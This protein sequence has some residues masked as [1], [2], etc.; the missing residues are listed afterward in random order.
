MI[1]DQTARGRAIQDHETLFAVDAGAGTGKTTLL[2]SRLI[3]LL[4]E[5][6]V[7]LGKIA[8]ITFTEKAA[9]ELVDR[10]RQKLEKELVENPAKK[11][12]ILQAFQ[13]LERA[14]ISTIHSFCAALLREYP[15][16]AGVDPRFTILDDVQAGAFESQAWEDWLKK[17][18]NKPV[19]SL[20]HFQRLGGTFGHLEE[21]KSF[22]KRN[23]SLL[24]PPESQALPDSADFRRAL[25]KFLQ[26]V[27]PLAS[28]CKD[29]SDGL[30]EAL[31][32]F[33]GD[34]AFLGTVSPEEM[35]FGLAVLEIPKTAK[36]GNQKNWDKTVLDNI[37]REFSLLSGEHEIFSAAFKNA[38]VLN[39]VHW[40]W[41]YLK[42]FEEKKNR[43]GFLDFDDLLMRTRNLLKDH[44]EAR[45]ELKK[46]LD[47]L[48]VDEFQDTDPLQVEIVFFLAEKEGKSETNWK[49]VKLKPG[50][51]FL[52]GDPKQSIY[53][54]RRADVE[55]YEETKK[56]VTGNGG[57]VELLTE[58][59][60]TVGS[61][62]DWVNARF[63]SLFTGTP[64]QYSA[65]NPS[66]REKRPPK[67]IPPLIGIRI[68]VP[69]DEKTAKA[70]LRHREAEWTAAFISEKLLK[71]GWTLS[72]PKT[73]E[74]R[75]VEPGD[76][77]VLFRDLSNENEEFWEEAFRKRNLSYQIVGGKRFYKRPEI[78]ALSTLLN[79]L[80]S[81]ADEA[82]CVA[83][84]RS[85]LFGF[86][87]EKIFLHRSSGGVF[88]FL[89]PAQKDM[90]E[91]FSL[92][93]DLYEKTRTLSVSETLTQFL[94]KTN[95]LAVVAAQ[96]HG[97]QRVA[98][99][100]KVVDQA[101]ELETSQHF[102]Y[103]AFTQWLAAQQE[104]ET[105]EGEAP[106]PDSSENRVT[107]MTI[108]KAKGLEF[109][110]VIVSGAASDSKDS[111]SLLE[112]KNSAGAYKAGNIDLG[113]RTLNY[114]GVRSEEQ[115][116]WEAENTRLL[117]VA[118]T[119]AMECL[120]LPFFQLPMD[121]RIKSEDLFLAPLLAGLETSPAQG[122][123]DLNPG[124][125][126]W[127]ENPEPGKVSQEDPPA[128]VVD[129]DEK[130]LKTPEAKVEKEKI[131]AQE[132]SRRQK[133]LKLVGI[134][135]F[136]SITS[137]LSV[138]ED[139]QGRQREILEEEE[140][141]FSSPGGK[142]FG[143]LVHLL[144]EKGWD[145]NSETLSRAALLYGEKLGVSKEEAEEA[146]KLA[147]R[148]VKSDL[149]Q[150]ARKADR[151]FHELPVT[152]A[153]EKG[154]F[155]NAVIDLAFLEGDE[156][157]LVDYKTDRDM[158]KEKDKY[159]KQLGYYA[160]LLTN[161]T[162]YPVKETW[163]YFLRDPQGPRIL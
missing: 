16:E 79:C 11:A 161:I 42:E 162:G 153:L 2:V 157:V 45:E 38:V 72:D 7:S 35:V 136:Q 21:L 129:L 114:E 26:K 122:W 54:F 67:A 4:V 107:L 34:C 70:S 43:Q 63:P 124:G 19:G 66:R 88:Q 27:H 116:Q 22:L 25:K 121:S 145:W 71:G 76:L 143:S 62:V 12:L 126:I 59:F 29:S 152:G 148:A 77:A 73:H 132:E 15:V 131:S 108:H 155:L 142:D 55:I 78:V 90:E 28:S 89:K 96:P 60:R 154:S 141:R 99:L 158:E 10:L 69:P 101:R 144:L 50:K 137:K 83:A 81:P 80:S 94:E 138:D 123:V 17:S 163:L 37:R 31:Q 98:N 74:L 120:I 36:K 115:I 150:R 6:E 9:A 128:L 30:F 49:K 95:L 18:L 23:H 103:R 159:Q 44:P 65:Q 47:Y 117:Y 106:G 104:D 14:P 93:R 87:D 3:S 41:D 40:L 146:A 48:L 61:L 57:R 39:I 91:A 135:E 13:D 32:Q 134:P 140:T 125:K 147:E 24:T 133:I 118:A 84:L 51:L 127:V 139:K 86:T 75:P 112:R 113:L 52:V 151:V 119:R 102:T 82:A 111:G 92:L 64:I 97:E 46:R 58:N 110:V 68:A 53:R 8:A 5:K 160:T 105:M 109:P 130:L 33:Q 100:L 156:W 56:L 1:S 149:L 85:S 20:F